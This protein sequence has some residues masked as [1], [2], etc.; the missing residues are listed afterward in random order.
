MLKSIIAGALFCSTS[1]ATPMWT[2]NPTMPVNVS[3]TK[4]DVIT[5]QYLVT[6]NAK[7]KTLTMNPITGI[8]QVTSAGNCGNPFSLGKGQSCYLTLQAI[9]SQIT[10]DIVGGPVVC[11]SPVQCYQPAAGSA[12]NVRLID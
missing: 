6:N 5:L 8:Y 7:P 4:L 3:M 12:L 11:S 9:G 10:R 1:F 2:L